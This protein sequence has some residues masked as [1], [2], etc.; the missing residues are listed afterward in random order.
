M[1]VT[2]TSCIVRV[3]PTSPTSGMLY[4]YLAE[5]HFD[6]CGICHEAQCTPQDGDSALMKEVWMGNTE[7][8]ME[9]IKAGANLNLQNKVMFVNIV[10]VYVDIHQV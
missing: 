1:S 2:G 7:V 9:L 6:H 8:V 10:Y 5:L 4:V 3:L